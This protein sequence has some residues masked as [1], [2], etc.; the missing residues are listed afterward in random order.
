MSMVDLNMSRYLHTYEAYRV[1]KGTKVK[2]SSGED[3]VLS[4]DED[5]LVLTK[6]AGKQLVKDRETVTAMLQCNADMAALRSQSAA[7]EKQAEDEAKIMAVY[8]AMARGD[9]V[10]ASDEKKLME[11]NADLYQAAKMAQAMARTLERQAKRKKQDSQ[12]DK[13]EEDEFK[14]K[15]RKLNDEAEEASLNIGRGTQEFMI[16]QRTSIVEVG[17]AGVDFSSIEVANLGGGITGM[18]VDF[19]V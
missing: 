18:H 13:K 1:P 4:N 2:N 15:M 3:I 6:K 14:L 5:V 16:A 9:D 10:P 8:R 7:K 17:S 12:W 11:Y 19:S